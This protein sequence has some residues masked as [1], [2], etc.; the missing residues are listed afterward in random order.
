MFPRKNTLKKQNDQNGQN[1]NHA[2]REEQEAEDALI[3]IGNEAA[4]QIGELPNLIS[5]EANN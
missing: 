1:V 4:G 3:K 5:N 2:V